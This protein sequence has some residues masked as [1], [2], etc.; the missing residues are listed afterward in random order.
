VTGLLENK[1]IYRF[2]IEDDLSI[3]DYIDDM[4]K[5]GSWGG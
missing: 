2:Y 5:D 4:R 3:E 1:E